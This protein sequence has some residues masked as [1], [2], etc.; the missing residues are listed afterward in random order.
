[1]TF[2]IDFSPYVTTIY[3]N[4]LGPNCNQENGACPP[5][6]DTDC[7]KCEKSN[8]CLE[9][10]PGYDLIDK[11]SDFRILYFLKS[12]LNQHIKKSIDYGDRIRFFSR[13]S[14]F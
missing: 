11:K 8:Q 7:L 14:V 12:N 4:K 3:I 13:Y 1:M 5:I 9:C 6:C 10:I 2:V